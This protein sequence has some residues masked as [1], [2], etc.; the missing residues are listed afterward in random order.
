MEAK[1]RL[2]MFREALEELG[3][4]DGRNVR[5]DVR[6]SG[7]KANDIR[8]CARTGRDPSDRQQRRHASSIAAYVGGPPRYFQSL[9][10][11]T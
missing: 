8:S 5:L 1:A 4:N 3:W 7:T 11:S 2:A 9:I 10:T 6:R